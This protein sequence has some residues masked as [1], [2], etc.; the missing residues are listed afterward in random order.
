MYSNQKLAIDL[1]IS[2]FLT[3][4][5]TTTILSISTTS[6]NINTNHNRIG[7]FQQ[8]STTCIIKELNRTITMYTLF[9]IILLF[10]S[11]LSSFLLMGTRIDKRNRCYILI[12]LTLFSAGISMTM[13]FLRVHDKISVNGYSA[14]IFLIDIV[15]TY[16]LGGISILHGSMFYF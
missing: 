6:W 1:L 2:V 9:A 10:I 11:T 4:I 15:L 7:L 8:C 13:A 5:L 12:P 16:V 3:F 14:L